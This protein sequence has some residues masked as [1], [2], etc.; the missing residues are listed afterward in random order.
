[1]LSVAVCCRVLSCAALLAAFT[2]DVRT[3]QYTNLMTVQESALE[4]AHRNLTGL[5][6]TTHTS[7]HCSGSGSS[8]T[9]QG[10]TGGST[11]GTARAA[12]PEAAS[13]HQQHA[14]AV[15]NRRKV[16]PLAFSSAAASAAGSRPLRQ[17]GPRPQ[18]MGAAAASL[19]PPQAASGA[20][21][22]SISQAADAPAAEQS[23]RSSPRTL[24]YAIPLQPIRPTESLVA[25][26]AASVQVSSSLSSGVPS[27]SGLQFHV[28]VLARFPF[29]VRELAASELQSAPADEQPAA[30]CRPLA[31]TVNEPAAATRCDC[32][33]NSGVSWSGT[34]DDCAVFSSPPCTLHGHPQVNSLGA[35]VERQKLQQVRLRRQGAKRA[36]FNSCCSVGHAHNAGRKLWWQKVIWSVDGACEGP[37]WGCPKTDHGGCSSSSSSQHD[38]CACVCGVLQVEAFKLQLASEAEAAADTVNA[39]SL[40]RQQAVA[41]ARAP[42][43]AGQ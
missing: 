15:L 41:A 34:H 12:A 24:G 7:S 22:P 36:H 29:L 37:W 43:D 19:P 27:A 39:D 5:S 2:Y 13:L 30:T 33:S 35:Y 14:A 1:M 28:S 20:A 40:A 8:N 3:R 26:A 25:A 16:A 32:S 23:A 4:A 42:A 18:R 21:V 38:M 9:Q 17:D 10:S 6:T 31:A 11:A